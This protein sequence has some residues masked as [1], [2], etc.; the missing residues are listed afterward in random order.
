MLVHFVKLYNSVKMILSSVIKNKAKIK[1]ETL[2]FAFGVLAMVAI[3]LVVVVV[4]GIVKV[5]NQQKQINT[6][7]SISE[8]TNRRIDNDVVKY[9]MHLM[10][11]LTYFVIYSSIYFL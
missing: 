8:E 10:I 6:L 5:Y 1:M 3:M 7:M 4:A 11:Y 9:I 2:S